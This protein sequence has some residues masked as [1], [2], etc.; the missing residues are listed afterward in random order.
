MSS[1]PLKDITPA[2]PGAQRA[3]RL[4]SVRWYLIAAALA[5][6]ALAGPLVTRGQLAM[7]RDHVAQAADLT[8]Q[9]G[10]VQRLAEVTAANVD[11]ALDLALTVAER[12]DRLSA[13]ARQD[14]AIRQLHQGPEGIDYATERLLSLASL[15]RRE[16]NASNPGLAAELLVQGREVLPA[17]LA[18]AIAWHEARAAEARRGAVMMLAALVA[19]TLALLALA[20]LTVIGPL[21]GRLRQ[22]GIRTTE[23]ERALRRS[24]RRDGLTG[25]FNRSGASAFFGQNWRAQGEGTGLIHLDLRRFRRINQMLGHDAGDRVL[26]TLAERLRAEAREGDVV[27]R[28]GGDQFAM[29]IA[30]IADVE[31]LLD[32]GHD[33]RRMLS[34]PID[35]PGGARNIDCAIGLAWSGERRVDLQRLTQA[36]DI[37]LASARS[38]EGAQVCLFTPEMQ[39]LAARQD[40]LIEDLRGGLSRGDIVAFFQPQVAAAD[41]RPLGFEALVRWR[42]PTRGLLAPGEFLAMAEEA[43]YAEEIGTVMLDA[44]LDA[45]LEWRAAGF[46]DQRV[47][48]NF[49]SGQLADPLLADRIKWAVDQRG[50][51]AGCLAL[52]V[53]EDVM[54]ESDDDLPVRTIRHLADA[55]FSIELDD[56]GTGHAAIANIRRFQVSRIKIDRSFVRGLDTRPE[57][58]A[59]AEAM[60]RMADALGV[61]TLAEGVETPEERAALA[62]LGCGAL[63]GYNI[64]RPMPLD[65]TLSWLAEQDMLARSRRARQAAFERA[66]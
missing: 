28:I 59:L 10:D 22:L 21:L 54:V 24:G 61:E 34:D 46:A 65:E 42:H 4:L 60:L 1:F 16:A 62:A 49:S 14:P 27:I 7:E 18:T 32:R 31:A 52:E 44:A 50:L 55:G 45:V 33:L 26:V 3:G 53:V 17:R 40:R 5:V 64:A 12:S 47:A 37:A 29:L 58:A 15:A 35:L 23:L 56:F 38:G 25:L 20:S 9:I 2:P 36:A 66:G 51:E 41:G 57:Q 63:Q 11:G 30:D 13:A 43:G 19:G 6:V 8:A 39:R 48:V